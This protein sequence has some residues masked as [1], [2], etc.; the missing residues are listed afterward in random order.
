MSVDSEGFGINDWENPH[1]VGINK[2][3]GHATLMPYATEREALALDRAA[4]PY[5]QSLNGR[6]KFSYSPNPVSAPEG[7]ELESFDCSAW[8]EIEVPS[9]WEMQG[10]GM[11]IY[12]NIVLPFPVED[13]PKISGDNNPVGCYRR[14][15]EVSK[16]WNG[17]EIFIHFAGVDSA[18]Y[19]WINGQKVGYS[20]GSRTPAEFNVTAYLKPGE[21]S[22][23]ARVY[24][25]S[26]GSYL[27]DQDHWWLSGIYREVYL[28]STPKVH[29]RDFF[30][31]PR[32]DE[33]CENAVLELTARVSVFDL[34]DLE[35]YRI[36][37]SLF[38]AAGNAVWNHPVSGGI[39]ADPS[40][41]VT[42]AKLT[43][44]VHAPLLWSAE[45]P[46]LY[47]LVLALKDSTGRAIEYES[48]RIGFRKVELKD[49]QM[50]VNNQPVLI[51]GVNR[52]DHSDTR[53][54]AVTEEDMRADILLM[55][56]F[57]INAVRTSH[58]PNDPRF[59]E[60]CD[61]YGLYVF[62]ETNLETHGTYSWQANDDNWI[63]P[64]MER[65][66]RMVQ[67]DKNHPSVIVWSLGNESG[68]GPNHAAMCGWIRE[69][70][71]TRIV[72][73]E[74]AT[75]HP[76]PSHFITDMVCP[77][78][79]SITGVQEDMHGFLKGE[80]VRSDMVVQGADD[81]DDR[82]YIICEYAHSMGN[83]TGNLKEY[84]DVIRSHRRCQG[85]FIWDW[86]DQGIKKLTDE[87]VEYWGYGGDFGDGGVDTLHGKAFCI[88]GLV[89]PDR[90][91][92]P[93]M[94]ELKKVIQPV[95]IS[96]ENLLNGMVKITNENFFMDLGNLAASWQL[97]CDGE[98]I[99]NGSL[100]L[101]YVAPG[102]SA[103]LHVPFSPPDELKA[104]GEYFLNIAFVLA[105]DCCWAKAGHRVASEQFKIPFEVPEAPVADPKGIPKLNVK[106]NAE[107]ITL[108]ADAFELIFNKVEGRIESMAHN[109]KTI[110]AEGP[111]LNL[112]RAP[113]DNEIY[114]VAPK[115][116]EAG[117]DRLIHRVNNVVFEQSSKQMATIRIETRVQANGVEAG[118]DCFQTYCIHGS[119]E[120][121]I[122]TRVLPFGDLPVLPRVGITMSVPK[123]YDRLDWYGRG[124]HENYRDRNTSADVGLYGGSVDEQ[125]VPYICPQ[126]NGN[127]TDVRWV[128]LTQK[129]EG[130][131]AVAA[132]KIEVSAHYFTAADM[133]EAD[134]P[135]ELVQ[136]DLIILNL[137]YKQAGLGGA[138]CGPGPL[139]PYLVQ[140]EE[141]V[142]KIRLQPFT[143]GTS[144][145][146]HKK[147]G[148]ARGELKGGEFAF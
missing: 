89:W 33:K 120:V 55:K 23:S 62:D 39:L 101:P 96:A 70:D 73:Y 57:N 21:N 90:Q 71:P 11:P 66:M 75:R 127:K 143:G 91:P 8:D 45:K 94:W 86:L 72:H 133:A 123:A 114:S 19:L 15:F 27:E 41:A 147:T 92:H 44:E 81:Q 4:S 63:A 42:H 40:K 10:Y 74:G 116:Y 128:S 26:D 104:A 37:M 136:R 43:K 14:E 12:T 49:A 112:W 139:P 18:F 76:H 32:L 16:D 6:W 20:Q 28:F 83:S 9:N 109:G 25:W 122:E 148:T 130:L 48:S 85:G 58:Y 31:I 59:Y 61:E 35:G 50:L 84:W 69:Y 79:P 131:L 103:V 88:N 117:L 110:L 106:E 77:M 30:A 137:D 54:K 95:Q 60:L 24:R 111:Q 142:F 99:Q 135:H 108:S 97:V 124:P 5:H 64:F 125:F 145:A 68:Y 38:N 141:I 3:P 65:C 98:V 67:R 47:T 102:A 80:Y 82:P 115:W 56:Q 2:E 126:E 53:G 138:S 107:L 134:H 52:H 17:R 1:V 132:D 34:A 146:T 105:A 113:T 93:A 51:K 121:Q 119:G 78:Y 13:C 129:G 46:D 140:P 100:D 22:L 7:F 144:A 36:E 29:I 87:G 118:F